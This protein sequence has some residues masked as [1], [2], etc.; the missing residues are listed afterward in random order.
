MFGFKR[1]NSSEKTVDEVSNL[2]VRFSALNSRLISHIENF[3]FAASS[4]LGGMPTE[5][6]QLKNMQKHVDELYDGLNGA[7]EN[8]NN[9]ADPLLFSVWLG[10]IKSIA[11]TYEAS[12]HELEAVQRAAID[13][14]RMRYG[15]ESD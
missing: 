10:P 14:F 6:A 12:L 5:M 7:F 11:E 8:L 9:G 1:K 4:G 3:E 15:H 2:I 13:T